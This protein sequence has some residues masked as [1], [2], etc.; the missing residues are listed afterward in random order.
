[1]KLGIIGGSGLYELEAFAAE[2]L[3][4][5]TPYGDV[6]CLSGQC[7]GL[8]LVFLC[9]HGDEHK[10]PPHRINYRANIYALAQ[11]GVTH[12]VATNAVGGIA[13][14]A[15][16]MSLIVPDQLIDYSW[17]REQSFFDNFEL[18]LKH[19]DFSQ[20]FDAHLRSLLLNAARQ[21]NLL[22][23]DGACYACTQGPRLETAAE[24][25]RLKNDGNDIVGMTLMPEAALAKELGLAY[26]SLCLSVNWAAGVEPGELIM[27][28]IE[29]NMRQ[30]VLKF[31]QFLPTLMSY[32]YAN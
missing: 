16:P 28:D 10:V 4:L 1:M 32:F 2:S 12:V 26:A 17:G 9:R 13:E 31:K 27:A 11:L 20:P 25:R 8:P 21:Q 30:A 5:E 23:Q 29:N 14:F 19:I 24:I 15:A 3:L 18:G 7:R 22:I 6:S